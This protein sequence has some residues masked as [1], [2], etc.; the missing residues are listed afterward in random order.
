MFK[1]YVMV[2]EICMYVSFLYSALKMLHTS[3]L[4]FNCMARLV[5]E[6]GNYLYIWNH[7]QFFFLLYTDYFVSWGMGNGIYTYVENSIS[8]NINIKFFFKRI[9]LKKNYIKICWYLPN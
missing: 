7:D 8:D 4:L 3:I 2:Y 9:F 5:V 6:T 1:M